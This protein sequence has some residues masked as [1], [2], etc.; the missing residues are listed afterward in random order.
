MKAIDYILKSYLWSDTYD[1]VC[2]MFPSYK[3]GMTFLLIFLSG[4][5]ANIELLFGFKYFT[6]IAFLIGAVIE[7]TSGIYAS[8]SVRKEPFQSQKLGRFGFKFVLLMIGLFMLT[9]FGKEWEGKNELI[10]T[11]FDWVYAF[12]FTLGALEYMT[13]ILENYAVTQGKPKDYYVSIIRKKSDNI[14]DVPTDESH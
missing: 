11:V 5:T 12:I 9:Q 4:F 7:L 2:S 6:F 10:K 8:I 1:F 13:S 14:L 3:Y